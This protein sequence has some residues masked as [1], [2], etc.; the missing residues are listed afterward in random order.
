MKE[1]VDTAKQAGV[2]AIIASDIATIKYANEIGSEVHIS[3]QCNI[4][5]LE[6]VKFYS[7]YADVVVLARELTLKQIENICNEIKKQ[8]I[9]GPKGKL[10]EVEIFA[11]GALCV[12]VS[13]ICYMGLAQFNSSA[14][15]GMCLQPCRRSYKITDDET[16]EELIVDN[17]YI[18]S[19]KD[20]C[21]IGFL[22]QILASGIKVLKLEGR[23][24]SPD[25]VYTVVKTYREAVDSIIAKTYSKEKIKAWT[26]ELES[27]FNRGFWHGGYYLRKKLGEWSGTYGSKSTKEKHFIGLVKHYYPKAK[28]AE[29][30]MQKESLKLGDEILITGKTTG[31]IKTKIKSIYVK[32]SPVKQANKEDEDITISLVEK[33]RKGDKIYLLTDRKNL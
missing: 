8:N 11:H 2:T 20:L 28:I 1:I 7:K 3:T 13:G 25:Y 14:N 9:R 18:M 12:A 10:V 21:T 15:R 30:E 17:K 22:D 6:A 19:P 27:V 26:K 23:G 5:N 4:S 24:R 29:I 32:E 16:G 31:V 33:V